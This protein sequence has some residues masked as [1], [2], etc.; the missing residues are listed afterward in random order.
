MKPALLLPLLV[1]GAACTASLEPVDHGPDEV[2]DD[3]EPR[4]AG[5]AAPGTDGQPCEDGL[6]CTVEDRCHAGACLGEE[7]PCA[8]AVGFC[9]VA[10]CDEA[11][12]ACVAT[13]REPGCVD[14]CAAPKLRK[15]YRKGWQKGFQAVSRAWDRRGGDCTRSEAFVQR[16]SARVEAAQAQADPEANAKAHKAC[17]RAGVLDGAFA[18]L[19]VVQGLCDQVCFLDGEVVGGLAARSFCALAAS[20][21]AP[22]EVDGW[23]RGPVDACGL[24]YETG[25]DATFIGDT[26]DGAA[27]CPGYTEGAWEAPWDATRA[28]A[29][30]QPAP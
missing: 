7:R 1:V 12:D 9:H 2:V 19:A 5:C 3:G 25:C 22:P 23:L 20:A 4:A 27:G 10:T 16:I 15:F 6:W 14:R 17:R 29:C 26:I 21:G 11:T 8:D 24:S 30:D 28:R 18:A 13:A